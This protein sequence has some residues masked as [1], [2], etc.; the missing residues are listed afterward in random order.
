MTTMLSLKELMPLLELI[1]TE[2]ICKMKSTS[3]RA[4]KSQQTAFS[5][6]QKQEKEENKTEYAKEK[7]LLCK[8]MGITGKG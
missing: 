5:F 6:A 3:L 2:I 7:F 8:T 1:F 4:V